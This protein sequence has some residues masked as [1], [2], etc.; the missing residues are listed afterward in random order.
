MISGWKWMTADIN[1]SM[2][3]GPGPTVAPPSPTDNRDTSLPSK[4]KFPNSLLFLVM[5]SCKRQMYECPNKQIRIFSDA[6]LNRKQHRGQWLVSCRYCAMQYTHTHTHTHT[7]LTAL[8]PW[9]PGW[10]GTNLDFTEAKR[11]WVAVASPGP[12]ATLHLAPDR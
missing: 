2:H 7:C 10:A 1:C 6:M 8:F 3:F 9:L 11:Q 5:K 4:P 12:Y